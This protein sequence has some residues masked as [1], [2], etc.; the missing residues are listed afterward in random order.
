LNYSIHGTYGKAAPV[1]KNTYNVALL[2][3]GH[4]LNDFYCNF[5]PIL[6]PLLIS[7]MGLSLSLSG[8]LVMAMAFTAN[9]MQPVFG[10]YMDK[11]NSSKLLLLVVPMGAFFICMVSFAKSFAIL[12]LLIAL[13][14]LAVSIF[15]PMA[16]G[17][18]SKAAIPQK[19]GMSLSLFIGGGN[20]GFAFAPIVLVY[21][22]QLY[23]LK[24]LPVLI[25]PAILLSLLYYKADLQKISTVSSSYANKAG[26]NWKQL[27][28]N[29]KLMRLNAAMAIRTWSH[30]A[31]T[32]FLPTLLI[33]NGYDKALA[34]WLLTVFLVGAAVGGLVGGY[35][36]D[37]IGYKKI[38]WI[39]MFLAIFP[40]I[41]FLS[42]GKVNLITIT[43]LALCGFFLQAPHPSSLVWC[44]KF[45]PNNQNLAS[46]MMLGLSFG[47]GGIGAAVTAVVAESIGLQQAMMM[48]VLTLIIGAAI[49][50]FLPEKPQE[51]DII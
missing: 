2:S 42:S 50:Y 16:T 26:L 49:V 18:V 29:K 30:G 36:N 21:F 31:M 44:Q 41:Y 9:V 27:F 20:I 35:I 15:H 1:S 11:H 33:L 8:I 23:S 25:I 10:Y 38:I 43:M 48:T 34:G 3:M 19:M 7:N 14:G 46:G 28:C 37:R 40:A 24:M 22:L 39:S 51:K 5:L 17:I 13:S 6:I 47:I 45:L 4:L 12:L 32:T